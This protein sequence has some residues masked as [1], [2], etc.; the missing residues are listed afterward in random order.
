MIALSIVHGGPG[1]YFLNCV[2]VNYLFDGLEG[3]N[4]DIDDIADETIR[5]RLLKV[6]TVLSIS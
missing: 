4:P 5:S 3:V 1:P 6:S 2:I